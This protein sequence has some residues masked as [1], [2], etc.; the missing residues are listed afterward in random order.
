M[1]LDSWKRRL[2]STRRP[3]DPSKGATTLLYVHRPLNALHMLV[4]RQIVPHIARPCYRNPVS[5]ILCLDGLLLCRFDHDKA[6]EGSD[7]CSTGKEQDDGYPD[8]PFSSWKEIVEWMTLNPLLVAKDG[9]LFQAQRLGDK[10]YGIN[11]GHEHHPCR[12]VKKD[13]RCDE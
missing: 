3:D 10:T 9:R 13:R 11:E 12:V 1:H 8:S 4:P 5:L 7:Q 6:K 2:L